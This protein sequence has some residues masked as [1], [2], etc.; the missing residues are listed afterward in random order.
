[1]NLVLLWEIF[2]NIG[3]AVGILITLGTFITI[4][5]KKP[6]DLFRKLIRDECT[7]A[8]VDMD[9]RLTNGQTEI[10]KHLEE[11]DKTDIVSLR[12]EITDIYYR[13]KDTKILPS[14]IKQSLLDMYERYQ[15]LGGNSYVHTIVEEMKMWDVD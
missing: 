8:T 4:V 13:Y 1:M 14:Y 3:S 12:H 10:I 9:E 7:A 11:S 15:T 2:Q 6:K 5:T